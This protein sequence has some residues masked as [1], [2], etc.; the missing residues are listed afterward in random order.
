[1]PPALAAGDIVG[2]VAQA[3]NIKRELLEQGCAT[4]RRMGY[5]PFYLD[6]ILDQDLYFA[7][8]VERRVR[9]LEHMFATPE[10]KG[11]ICARG[12]YGAN[13]LLGK[14]DVQRV[15]EHPKVF[16]G[17]SDNTTLLTHFADAAGLVVFH[18]PMVAKDF[19]CENGVEISSWQA[20]V[21][22]RA[23]WEVPLNQ[24]VI[25]LAEGTGQGV[26]YGGCLS[27]LA[28]S[29]GTP[30]EVRTEDKVLF[31]EDL[32][33]KPYQVDRMLMQLKLAGKLD[34]VR[35]IIFGEMLDCAQTQN[36]GYT[37]PEVVMRIV[38]D[39]GV[40]VAFG[41]RSGHVSGQNITLPM[42]V[43]AELQVRSSGVSL[44]ILEPATRLAETAITQEKTLKA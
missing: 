42:G 23:Q 21:S 33:A 40:P 2:I 32:A 43:R 13:Y 35:G 34:A 41:V 44:H 38:G 4:L 9:E 17:Y 15:A 11:I 28:A 12:G 3:S 22:G 39:A 25:G 19:A 31:L 16:V 1:L 27:M 18:G 14:L 37:L 24:E 26:L 10:V 36:Q 7:G 5:Q 30:Y 8:G 20:A 29:L 6:S